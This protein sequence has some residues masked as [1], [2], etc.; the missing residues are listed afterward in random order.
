MAGSALR[1]RVLPRAPGRAPTGRPTSCRR[2]RRPPGRRAPPQTERAPRQTQ[3]GTPSNR[4]DTQV[5]RRQGESS[6]GCATGQGA[7]P[8]PLVRQGPGSPD[9]PH[10]RGISRPGTGPPRPRSEP[11]GG[12]YSVPLR[13]DIWVPVDSIP[14]SSRPAPCQESIASAVISSHSVA[15]SRHVSASAR[16][17]AVVLRRRSARAPCRVEGRGTDSGRTRHVPSLHPAPSGSRAAAPGCF[18][19]ALSRHGPGGAT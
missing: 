10:A 3:A 8:G 16:T 7:G 14:S 4:A 13:E 19:P 6:P 17:H 2:C 12:E 1:R 15:M 9:R 18:E 5:T 11:E